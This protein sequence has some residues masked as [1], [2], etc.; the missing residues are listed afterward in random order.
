[1]RWSNINRNGDGLDQ[2]IFHSVSKDE[3]KVV[4]IQLSRKQSLKWR[5][6]ILG[7]IAVGVGFEHRENEVSGREDDDLEGFLQWTWDIQDH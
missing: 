1:M 6:W 2:D 7:S 5:D 3:L 4:G